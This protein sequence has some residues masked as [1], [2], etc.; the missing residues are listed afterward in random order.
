MEG[1]DA[2]LVLPKSDEGLSKNDL[3][4]ASS[5]L[6]RFLAFGDCELSLVA[7]L[8][9]IFLSKVRVGQQVVR[10]PIIAI[11][12]HRLF[13][14]GSRCRVVVPCQVRSTEKIQSLGVMRAELCGSDEIR[15]RLCVI[16]LL[17]IQIAQEEVEIRTGGRQLV[18]GV[19]MFLGCTEI[20][21]LERIDGAS[22][23]LPRV[24][25]YEL[26]THV[27]M[28]GVRVTIK[29]DLNIRRTQDDLQFQSGAE[30]AD[31]AH[32]SLVTPQGQVRENTS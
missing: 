7:S 21:R 6:S 12:E 30:V 13:Q 28:D 32:F 18:G 9:V 19:Q 22:C 2:F 3:R 1:L 20:T 11:L 25:R 26:V 16:L 15:P 14:S 23:F 24:R 27:K 10:E 5:L 17:K 8:L 29:H 31:S 4:R